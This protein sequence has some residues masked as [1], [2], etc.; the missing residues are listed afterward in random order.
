VNRDT[1]DSIEKVLRAPCA[2]GRHYACGYKDCSCDCHQKAE[3]PKKKAGWAGCGLLILAALL[4]VIGLVTLGERSSPPKS[5]A[6]LTGTTTAKH[7]EPRQQ[8]KLQWVR[9]SQIVGAYE[10]NEIAADRYFK[11]RKL[12]IKGTVRSISKDV[13]GSPFVTLTDDSIS[14]FRLVQASFS[15]DDE[16]SLA[17]LRPGQRLVVACTVKGLMI[18][19]LLDDCRIPDNSEIGDNVYK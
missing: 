9:P 19:V 14:G 18:N 11:D 7:S 12:A 4:V 16:G 13:L 1:G 10:N 5:W 6:E 17:D 2:E 3:K 8:T 15:R